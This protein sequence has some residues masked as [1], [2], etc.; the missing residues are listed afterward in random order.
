MCLSVEH[1]L[2]RYIEPAKRNSRESEVMA[3]KSDGK[4]RIEAN[5]LSVRESKNTPDE[6]VSDA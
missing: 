2:L 3:G 5:S 1:R 4:L 6:D